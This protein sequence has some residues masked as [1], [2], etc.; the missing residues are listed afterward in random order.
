MPRGRTDRVSSIARQE[1]GVSQLSALGDAA[2]AS[3]HA[4]L[5]YAV[6]AAGLERRGA[7]EAR[8]LLLRRSS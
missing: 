3:G 1:L 2:L 6:S 7:T 4:D 8:F 5:A